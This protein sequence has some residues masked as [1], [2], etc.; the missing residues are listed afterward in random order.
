[1]FGFSPKNGKWVFFSH[2]KT[3]P[4]TGFISRSA[5]VFKTLD[6]DPQVDADPKPWVQHKKLDFIDSQCWHANFCDF[7]WQHKLEPW[8]Q[9]CEVLC[10]W[11][12]SARI[13][14]LLPIQIRNDLII[15]MQNY[16][17]NFHNGSG[18]IEEKCSLK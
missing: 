15:R 7:S 18:L 16:I 2:L 11:S 9:R 10:C 8:T 13:R 5:F 17:C 4:W 6:T 14:N 12:R 3:G 1:V